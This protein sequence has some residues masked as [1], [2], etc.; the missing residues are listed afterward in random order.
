MSA[1]QELGAEITQERN[2]VKGSPGDALAQITRTQ[3]LTVAMGFF[4]QPL[5]QPAEFAALD[6][7]PQA[8]QVAR[9]CIHELGGVQIAERVGRE[10]TD[11]AKA[12]VNVLQ[13]TVRIIRNG[14]V[15]VLADLII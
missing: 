13:A 8:G 2:S 10:I 11:A 14:N 15:E 3:S 1:A 7:I 12:P 5:C 4:A 6:I 9:R